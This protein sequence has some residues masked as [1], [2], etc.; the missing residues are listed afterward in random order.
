MKK[1]TAICFMLLFLLSDYATG[2]ILTITPS[3]PSPSHLYVLSP[4][5]AGIK[6]SNPQTN[7]TGQ[8]ITYY[9]PTGWGNIGVVDVNSYYIPG[10]LS[11]VMEA[12]NGLGGTE[13]SSTGPVTVSSTYTPL[14]TGIA[15]VKKSISRQLTQSVS[16]PD[17]TFSQLHSGTFT[18]TINLWLH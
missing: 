6:P 8:Y 17:A 4:S 18:V 7:Y 13:G 15:K 5:G 16:I 12:S 2:Q 1:V 3:N 10:G 14:V 11:I 9:F